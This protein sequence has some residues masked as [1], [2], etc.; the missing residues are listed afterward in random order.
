MK[1]PLLYFA[2]ALAATDALR[3]VQ[4]P[5]DLRLAGRDNAAPALTPVSLRSSIEAR[6]DWP[7]AKW[8]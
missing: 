5:P 2:A 3:P 4:L 6:D 8:T 1:G 7:L